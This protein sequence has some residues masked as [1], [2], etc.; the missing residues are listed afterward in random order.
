MLNAAKSKVS[1]QATDTKAMNRHRNT[2]PLQWSCE[3]VCIGS[4]FG[5]KGVLHHFLSPQTEIPFCVQS[6]TFLPQK[7]TL[8]IA[9]EESAIDKYIL[10]K[11]IHLACWH[12]KYKFTV[13]LLAGTGAHRLKE[14][15]LI[16]AWGRY[17]LLSVLN[18]WTS[19]AAVCGH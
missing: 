15:Y 12:A 16:T 19:V 7:R 5:V 17:L 9:A 2:V 18:R 6:S 10:I 13:L 4:P 3:I 8:K 11:H 14:G 1:E